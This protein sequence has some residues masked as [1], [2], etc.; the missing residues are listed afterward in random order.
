MKGSSA[1]CGRSL[2][3][4]GAAGG[5]GP[6]CGALL[7]IAP[8]PRLLLR[9]TGWTPTWPRGC[10][11]R[12]AQQLGHRELADLARRRAAFAL[13]RDGVGHDHLARRTDASMRSTAGPESTGCTPA[14]R[15]LAAPRSWSPSAVF[16]SVPAV[17]MMSSTTTQFLP[18]DVADDVHHLGLVGAGAPLVDDRQAGAQPLGEGARPLD[19]AGVGRHHDE[20]RQRQPA[21]L[22]DQ[23]RRG[24]QVVDRDVEEPL[25]LRGVQ[26]HRQH[27]R[28][29]P[30]R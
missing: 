13:Q 2:T 21:E 16:T 9:R 29:P 17:S 4:A 15:T 27:A 10:A 22:L 7:P 5:S 19:A 23:H 12:L 6:P 20:V 18:V 1:S 14:A 26:V 24:E 11:D 8:R 25:D 30:P 28:W 3:G